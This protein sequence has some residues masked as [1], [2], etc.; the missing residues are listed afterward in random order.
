MPPGLPPGTAWQSLA[1]HHK[2]MR[3]VHM[4]DLFQ[5]DPRRASRY[6][7]ELNDLYLDYSK[8]LITDETLSL[9]LNLAETTG[10]AEAIDGLYR[11]ATINTSE[12]RPALHT[13]LRNGAG[14]NHPGSPDIATQVHTELE[15][16]ATLETMLLQGRLK[17]FDDHALD[18]IVNIGIGGSDLGPRLVTE[19]LRPDNRRIPDIHFITNIDPVESLEILSALDPRRTLV[20]VSSKSFC[21][22]ET[23]HNART[24][25]GW[26]KLAGCPD[27]R[28]GRHFFAATANRQAALEF[29]IAEDHVLNFWDWVGGRY[30]IWSTAGSSAALAIGLS[31][32]QR[33]LNGAKAIDRHFRQ[34]DFENNLP[35]ILGLLSVWYNNLY[36]A[37][38]RAVLPYDQRLRMLPDYLCQLLMES[39]GKSVTAAGQPVAWHTTPIV[40]GDVGTNAQHSFMQSLHQGTRMI[41]VDFLVAETDEYDPEDGHAALYANCLAQAQA[42]MA[43]GMIPGK[44]GTT[45]PHAVYPGNRPSNTL[46]YRSLTPEALG[47][48]LAIYEHVTFVQA[49]LWQIN[50]FDQ[51]GVEL[52]KSLATNIMADL[53]G[54]GSAPFEN[55]SYDSST[56]LLI[57]RYQERNNRQD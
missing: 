55:E 17:G 53:A 54:T 41:P 31:E 18:T 45:G 26:L 9:L 12:Q 38:G 22:R 47:A 19:A 11:G 46:L 35:V 44:S 3:S 56:A 39:N 50:P 43:G 8:N 1:E 23:L 15:R 24:L 48:I 14:E 52:G 16:L 49:H 32:Y 20:F 10:L 57:K 42:L 2:Q 25:Q 4:R 28:L 29:G 5:T 6:S 7:I 36:E 33:M 37:C 40:M 21:T 13:A 51:W 34:S 27:N 30:S